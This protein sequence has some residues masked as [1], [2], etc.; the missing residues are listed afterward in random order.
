MQK[1]RLL[2]LQE[3]LEQ[4][5][6]IRRREAEEKKRL[7]QQRVATEKESFRSSD[8]EAVNT[9]T[10]HNLTSVATSA[11]T[12]PQSRKFVPS[13]LRNQGSTQTPQASA[14][15]LQNG[16]GVSSLT[17]NSI[18]NSPVVIQRAQPPL[19]QTES[20]AISTDKTK[21]YVVPHQRYSQPN[22]NGSENNWRR[23]Q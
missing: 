16:K 19:Q 23:K 15:N 10:T 17:R 12:Q 3:R 1:I 13:V 6:E 20:S 18:N 21:K 9:F 11:P 2:K 7:E 14:P 5:K 22:S 8:R 4:R